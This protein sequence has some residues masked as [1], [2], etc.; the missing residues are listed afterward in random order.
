MQL[1]AAR[2]LAI[3]GDKSGLT[4]ALAGVKNPNKQIRLT[5]IDTLGW[6]QDPAA[7]PALE[8]AAKDTDVVLKQAALR[9]LSRLKEEH[10]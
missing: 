2:A 3:H 4:L 7:V 5:A 1:S 6:M 9:S 8:E 10:K